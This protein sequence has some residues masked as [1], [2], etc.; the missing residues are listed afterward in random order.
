MKCTPYMNN[1]FYAYIH[2]LI[3]YNV[4]INNLLNSSLD[5]LPQI[6]PKGSREDRGQDIGHINSEC[7]TI[8]E[9]QY[10]ISKVNWSTGIRV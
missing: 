4:V 8:H 2:V 1:L 7:W 3:M 6:G 5:R 9:S 10:D